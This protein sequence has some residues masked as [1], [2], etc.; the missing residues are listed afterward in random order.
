MN[1]SITR[2]NCANCYETLPRAA[3]H[4]CPLCRAPITQTGFGA[5]NTC[6]HCNAFVPRAHAGQCPTCAIPGLFRPGAGLAGGQ[7]P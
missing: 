5:S 6:L 4:R 3:R 7:R 1:Y 2:I